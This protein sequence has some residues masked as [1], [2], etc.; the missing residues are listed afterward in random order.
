VP[1]FDY[2]PD[3]RLIGI[4]AAQGAIAAQTAPGAA[5]VATLAGLPFK[6]LEPVRTTVASDDSVWTAASLSNDPRKQAQS[7][8]LR[9]DPATGKLTGAS[10][11]FLAVKLAAVASDGKVA[12]DTTK[13]KGSI[14]GNVLRRHVSHGYSIFGPLGVK[15]NEPGQVIAQLLLGGKLV[16]WGLQSSDVAGILGV[17]FVLRK[18]KGETLRKAAAAHRRALVRMTVHDWAGNERTYERAVHLSR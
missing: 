7:R 18:G 3:G 4:D 9:Y 6:A 1:A 16:G 10:G 5:T 13:P 11:T 8:F 12:D 2:E 14:R 15:V 17:D